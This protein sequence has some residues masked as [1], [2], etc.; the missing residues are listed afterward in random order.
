MTLRDIL[1]EENYNKYGDMDVYSDCIDDFACCW[2]GTL[3]TDYGKDVYVKALDIKAEIRPDNWL[4]GDSHCILVLTDDE[5]DYEE[6]W[7]EAKAFFADM[8]G[9]I[10]DDDYRKRFISE[11]EEEPAPI[12]NPDEII[13]DLKCKLNRAIDVIANPFADD[14]EKLLRYIGL[15]EKE[16]KDWLY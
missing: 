14:K 12:E 16:I 15:S 7:D 8:A 3:L 13:N 1:T 6:L 10:P 4:G 5:E 2:C 11:A 9:Y